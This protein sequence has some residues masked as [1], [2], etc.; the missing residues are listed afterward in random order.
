MVL[1]STSQNYPK[2]RR[3]ALKNDGNGE[4]EGKSGDVHRAPV[5][6]K[7][8]IAASPLGKPMKEP[9]IPAAAQPRAE[10]G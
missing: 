5:V 3:K 6:R 9:R 10:A 1:T 8:E 4:N 7:E 2:R